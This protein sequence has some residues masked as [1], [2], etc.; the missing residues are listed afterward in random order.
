MFESDRHVGPITIAIMHAQKLANRSGRDAYVIVKATRY[1]AAT[2]VDNGA[3][4]FEIVHPA[5]KEKNRYV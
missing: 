4:V 2:N 1:L 3:K 5:P